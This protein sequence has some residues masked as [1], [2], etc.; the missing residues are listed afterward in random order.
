MG[1]RACS[2]GYGLK[3][4]ME[5]KA[6]CINEGE[7]IVGERG[8]RRRQRRLHL[9]V[10]LHTLEDFEVMSRRSRTSFDVDE[11]VKKIYAEK[12]IP[13]WKGKTMREK[14][15]GQMSRQWHT[16]FRGV[17]TEFMEQRAPGHA[18]FLTIK[19]TVAFTGHA[20]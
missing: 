1:L 4:L 19:Y 10:V 12:I 15:F 2:S 18:I 14:V 8:P 7:L 9:G 17:F 3:Y 11:S 20:G 5:H 13:F 16:A 6:L